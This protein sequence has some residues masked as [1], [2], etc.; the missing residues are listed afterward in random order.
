MRLDDPPVRHGTA[1]V[2]YLKNDEKTL[3][4]FVH[5]RDQRVDLYLYTKFQ[6][7]R[8]GPLPAFVKMVEQDTSRL[9]G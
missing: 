4:Y 2:K 1:R 8:V 5:I 6:T 3:F 7:N 9:S